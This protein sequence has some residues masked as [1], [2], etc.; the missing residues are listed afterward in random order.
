MYF[1]VY[2]LIRSKFQKFSDVRANEG[3]RP[4]HDHG[5]QLSDVARRVKGKEERYSQPLDGWISTQ[6]LKKFQ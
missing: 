6:C 4:F 1:L 2:L 3:I 5:Q